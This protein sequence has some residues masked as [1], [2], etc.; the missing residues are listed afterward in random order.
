M[1]KNSNSDNNAEVGHTRNGRTFKEVPIVN[2]FEQSHEPLTQDE[3]FYSGEAQELLTKE[4]SR[5]IGTE[6]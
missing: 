4:Y 5:S 6:E 3:G 1:F 2:L